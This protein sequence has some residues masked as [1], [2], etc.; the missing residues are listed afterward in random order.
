MFRSLTIT[1]L[2][3]DES[4]TLDVTS[5]THIRRRSMQG[6]TRAARGLM[7]LLTGREP[8]GAYPEPRG[9]EAITIEATTRTMLLRRTIERDKRGNL[10]HSRELEVNEVSVDVSSE[11]KWQAALEG[12]GA[13]YGNPDTLRL[14]CWPLHWRDLEGSDKDGRALRDA[15]L[16]CLDTSAALAKIVKASSVYREGD[17]L[18]E[19]GA[20]AARRLANK[21]A[22]TAE[23]RHRE[24]LEALQRLQAV[25]APDDVLLTRA[26]RTMDSRGAWDTFEAYMA[27]Y[28]A[29]VDWGERR[30]K[31]GDRPSKPAKAS[32]T[33]ARKHSDKTEKA[34][35][36][37]WREVDGGE[38][39]V[40][41]A[42]QM[43]E[44]AERE[45][46]AQPKAP[47]ITETCPTCE[48]PWD[49]AES[50]T[51]AAHDAWMD[52][53]Q[54]LAAQVDKRHTVLSE[55]DAALEAARARSVIAE[56]DHDDAAQQL[57][58][59]MAQ[60]SAYSGWGERLSMLGPEP[61]E[62]KP[63]V[64][65]P[66]GVPPTPLD[67]AGARTTVEQAQK[68]EGA[69]GL[70]EGDRERAQ[71]AI[72]AAESKATTA[73]DEAARLE[74]LVEV[75][76]EAPAQLLPY[77]IEELGQ[78][79]PCQVVPRGAGVTVHVNGYPHQEAS[80]GELIHADLHLRAAIRRAY[81]VRWLP[82]IVEQAQDWSEA[83]P[84][85]PGPV[86]FLWTER[87]AE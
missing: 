3:L 64:D 81:G 53:Q 87:A 57:E 41:E 44:V 54:R 63:I 26:R 6:K 35:A 14:V 40:R 67:V 51:T 71:K 38:G 19:K 16:G 85:I 52:E 56:G 45:R 36:E 1:G 22:S 58:D 72:E 11:K 5:P 39:L 15:L 12:V 2:G 4:I 10:K 70:R 34:R 80:Q 23:G 69:A 82:L 62:P 77:A 20:T 21:N 42:R 24:A 84:D 13:G 9:G 28:D 48:Q 68:A 49:E 33:G 8:W 31:L 27:R 83:W 66:A 25:E 32:I 7:L 65:Q 18:D 60:D 43:L 61:Q 79:G 75:I 76:R 73:A 74:R 46:A 29:W 30:Q 37:V 59:L 86:Y 50:T 55:A 47:A 78:L 17:P